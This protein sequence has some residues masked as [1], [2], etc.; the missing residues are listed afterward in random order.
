MTCLRNNFR[1]PALPV[2]RPWSKVQW[3]VARPG[4]AMRAV[5]CG[6]FRGRPTGRGVIMSAPPAQV[7]IQPVTNF[8]PN[9]PIVVDVPPGGS[10]DSEFSKRRTALSV[11]R[12]G[13]SEHRTDLSEKRTS[14]ASLRSHLANERTH[15]S[16]L[17]T[18]I[19]LIG[20]GTTLNRFA[21]ALVDQPVVQTTT[22]AAPALRDA[23]WVGFGMV[24]LGFAVLLW[25][26]FRFHRTAR[27]IETRRIH[28]DWRAIFVTTALFLVLGA[29]TLGWL[30]FR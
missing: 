6:Q 3:K 20:F 8:D 28:T 24:V 22:A 16:Y 26:L 15:L 30:F 29:T 12:T 4:R 18:S 11:H 21:A 25:S 1:T 13:L 17:R 10:P 27:D 19:S 9:G 23:K 5:K 14:L 2:R 7:T